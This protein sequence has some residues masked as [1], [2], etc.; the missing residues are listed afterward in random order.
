M[1]Q[2][3]KKILICAKKVVSLCAKNIKDRGEAAERIKTAS[4]KE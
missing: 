3:Y 1:A 2:N 4:L